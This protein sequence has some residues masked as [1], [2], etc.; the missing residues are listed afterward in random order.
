[1]T[2]DVALGSVDTTRDAFRAAFGGE[3]AGVWSAP[4]R[5][6]LIGEHTDYNDGFVLPFALR[7]RAWV[8]ARPRGDARVHLIS[9]ERGSAEL[10]LRDVGPGRPTG[11]AA[12]VTG[13][14]WALK[15]HGVEVG[16]LDV[17]LLSDVPVG[18]GLSSSAAVECASVLAAR[19]LFGGP[20]DLAELA[21]LAQR[22]ENV[23]AGVPCG[24][25]DQS[26]SLR[27]T[28][29]HVLALDTRSL[30]VEQ[31]P[32][33]PPAHGLALLITDTRTEHALVD[34][35]YAERRT[36]C[37]EAA[38]LLGVA[39]LR[40][41]TTATVD[42]AAEPLG[43][44]R[45]RRARHVTTENARV[46]DTVRLLRSGAVAQIG[47]LLTASHQSLRDDFEVTVPQLDVAVDAALQAGALG[48]RMT[49]AGF[50]GCTVSLVPQD[51]VQPVQSAIEDAFARS[52]FRPPASFVTRPSAGARRHTG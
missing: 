22:A 31:V 50:G 48:S 40:D 38:T 13:P 30:K 20:E 45:H 11:W 14:W 25:M 4:G 37:E 8:A 46:Q 33:D 29:G 28:S 39:A 43:P 49:G 3:P 35:A 2:S 5:V 19:D 6:N 12:Y 15:E 23:V 21:L 32:F 27:C 1:M 18:A 51:L 41:V 26:A 10:S 17:L 34:G 42:A 7:Q 44:V 47:A 16:G 52:G 36:A 24:I 9:A